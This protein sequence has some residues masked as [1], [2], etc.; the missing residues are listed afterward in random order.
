MSRATT[1]LTFTAIG[2]EKDAVVDL[3]ASTQNLIQKAV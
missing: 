1:T 2:Q 3:A